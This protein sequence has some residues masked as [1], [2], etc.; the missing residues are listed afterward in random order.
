MLECISSEPGS[1]CIAYV[2]VKVMAAQVTV[3]VASWHDQTM[4]MLGP[5]KP[6]NTY[7]QAKYVCC[8]TANIL[9]K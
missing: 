7:I 9:L 4:P 5:V 6:E 1:F 3:T 8:V 2:K